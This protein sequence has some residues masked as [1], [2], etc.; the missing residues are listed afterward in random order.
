MINWYPRVQKLSL[1]LCINY[2]TGQGKK[3]II[4]V[5]VRSSSILVQ[6]SLPRA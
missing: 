1:Q 6:N 2:K 5:H 3:L 4:Q